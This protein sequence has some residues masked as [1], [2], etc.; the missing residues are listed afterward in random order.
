M[1][2][3]A[4]QIV[5][6]AMALVPICGN[7]LS[8]AIPPDGGS[9]SIELKV[10]DG[11]RSLATQPFVNA[12]GEALAA[13]GFTILEDPGHA[14]Y[15]AE[16]TLSRVEVGTGLA[17]VPAGR[18][19]VAP[20]GA[21]GSVGAGV[22]IPLSMGRSDLVPLQRTRLEVR[23]RKRGE[24]GAVWDGAAVAVRSAG[25]RKGSDEAVASDLSDAVLRSYPAEPEGLIGVP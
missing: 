19:S 14:A 11:N 9:I 7:S 18:E 15:V 12:A 24:E 16:L 10:A 17:K 1:A 5:V 2:R 23:I 21:Y 3:R 25:T 8:A 20:G 13:R 4:V 22:T 6:A